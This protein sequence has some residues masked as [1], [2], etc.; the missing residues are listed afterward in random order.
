MNVKHRRAFTLVELLVVI[1]I[2]GI[3]VALLLPAVQAARE[4]ARRSSCLN[5][6]RQTTL[7]IHNYELAYGYLPVGTTNKTGPIRNV[8][9]GHHIS[10]LARTLP[11]I[12]EQNRANQLDL[13]KSAYHKANDQVRQTYFDLLMCP[14]YGGDEGPITTYAACHHDREAPIDVD[15]NGA[16]VLNKRITLDDISD[17][18]SYTIFIGEKFPEYGD[19]GWLSGTPSTLRNGGFAITAGGGGGM[20]GDFPWTGTGSSDDP[21]GFEEDPDAEQWDDAVLESQDFGMDG[22]VDEPFADLEELEGEVKSP[23]SAAPKPEA[24]AEDVKEA[25]EGEPTEEKPKDDKKPEDMSIY[26]VGTK[27]IMDLNK[28]FNNDVLTAEPEDFEVGDDTG[29]E[30]EVRPGFYLRGLLGGNWSS[31]LR[32]G[33]FQGSHSG[34]V[35]F[36]FGDG[37]VRSISEDVDVRTFRQMT[38]RHDGEIPNDIW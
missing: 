6:V 37:S 24:A 32:V 36:G 1:A 35:T 25:T 21:W 8:P 9:N 30:D 31:P 10:W 2:I 14:S 19:L 27:Y 23:E 3:L 18:A 22:E 11:Y 4:A 38:N 7:G 20:G 15:N 34:I 28:R 16:F 17:G 12:G 13:T 5:N 26:D 33:G 29:Y